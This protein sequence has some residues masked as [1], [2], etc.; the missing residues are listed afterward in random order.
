LM[1]VAMK[2]TAQ[3]RQRYRPITGLEGDG[4]IVVMKRR[5]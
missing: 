4:A 3:M 2:S 5:G 1:V